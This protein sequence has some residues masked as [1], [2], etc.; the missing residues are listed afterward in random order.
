MSVVVAAIGDSA[1]TGPVTELARVLADLLGAEVQA[2]HVEEADTASEPIAFA[3]LRRIPFRRPP[4][5]VADA[6]AT[7]VKERNPLVVVL[8]SG[9]ASSPAAPAGHVT[10]E[11]VQLLDV[12]VAV[13]PLQAHPRP[14]NRVLVAVE[15]D[16]ESHALR[17]LVRDLRHRPEVDLVA[18]HVFEPDQLPLFGDQPVLETEAWTEEF[19][20]R[21][22]R[23]TERAVQLEVRVGDAGRSL[24][25]TATELDVDLVVIA[26]H[27]NLSRGHGRLVRTMLAETD[28]PI[29]LFPLARD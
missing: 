17:R 1:E 8:G 10:M 29:V 13:V 4:G 24:C 25:E 18:L 7:A 16:G 11:L 15:G 19:G 23:R 9:G 2:I 5:N 22:L 3:P 26:W 28:R 20:R 14:I 27:R 21:M 12:A 6:I